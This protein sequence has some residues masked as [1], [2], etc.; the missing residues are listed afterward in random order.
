MWNTRFS[1]K[2]AG[3]VVVCNG[4]RYFSLCLNYREYLAHRIVFAA[5]NGLDLLSSNVDHID[6]NGLNNDPANLRL[7]TV[8]ENGRNRGAQRNNTSGKKGVSFEKRVGRWRASVQVSG[9]HVH[10]GH[11]DNLDEASAAYEA[12]ARK[13]FG[14]FY[15]PS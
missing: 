6:G 14:E 15:R 8:A 10:I 7:A 13:H 11:Y 5:A 12:S 3:R 9:K 2:P 1:G 4:K